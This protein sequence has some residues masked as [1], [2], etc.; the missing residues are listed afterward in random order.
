MKFIT[1][2]LSSD[3]WGDQPSYGLVDIDT[4]FAAKLISRRGVIQ[5]ICKQDVA[6]YGASFFSHRVEPF[7]HSD[8]N[9]MLDD[10]DNGEVIEC[11]AGFNPLAQ[12]EDKHR[13]RTDG[14]TVV[15]KES[16]VLFKFYGKHSDTNFETDEL[17]WSQIES[18]ADHDRPVVGHHAGMTCRECGESMFLADGNVSHHW[19]GE[20]PDNIDHDADADHVAI[21][22]ED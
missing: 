18:A 16:G 9:H 17:T 7:D 8:D 22:D 19:S 13:F 6:F 15:V 21:V 14:E 1:R 12:T 5:P 11:P 20:T 3:S 4:E 10:V 2:I